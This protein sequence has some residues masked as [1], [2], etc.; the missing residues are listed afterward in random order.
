MS[1]RAAGGGDG[2]MTFAVALDGHL[3]LDRVLRQD[4]LSARPEPFG[5]VGQCVHLI[6]GVH[7]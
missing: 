7:P 1:R 2:A 5:L 4:H 6:T 3:V